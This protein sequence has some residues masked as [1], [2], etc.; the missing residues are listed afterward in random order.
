M[1]WYGAVRALYRGGKIVTFIFDGKNELV[2]DEFL[3][4][5]RK[6]MKTSGTCRYLR[7]EK[8]V[9]MTCRLLVFEYGQSSSKNSRSL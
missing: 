4:Y 9:N 3:W 6:H 8:I 1:V 5:L 7:A 2:G